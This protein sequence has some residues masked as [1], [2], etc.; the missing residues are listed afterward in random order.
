MGFENTASMIYLLSENLSKLGA[1]GQAAE[2]LKSFCDQL[3][4]QTDIVFLVNLQGNINTRVLGLLGHLAADRK[5]KRCYRI[6]Q[7]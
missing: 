6:L 3:E 1:N 5:E 4:G 7:P 2:T